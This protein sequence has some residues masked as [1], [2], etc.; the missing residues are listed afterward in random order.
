[1]QLTSQADGFGERRDGE[2]A[3]VVAVCP[4]VYT[5]YSTWATAATR[6]GISVTGGRPTDRPDP[7]AVPWRGRCAAPSSTQDEERPSD[8][9]RRETGHGTQG[10]CHLRWMASGTDGGTAASRRGCRRSPRTCSRARPSQGARR[11]VKGHALSP[12]ASVVGAQPI[13]ELAR[14]H[15]DQPGLRIVRQAVGYHC[16]AAATSASCSAS[17][18]ASTYP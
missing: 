3:P 4:S 12:C 17:S 2:A 1:M 5:R 15:P 13:D 16:R 9:H 8:L 6:A 11:H 14:R 10:E 18:A 7:L